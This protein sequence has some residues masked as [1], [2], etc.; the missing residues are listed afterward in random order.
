MKEKFSTNK[1]FVGGLPPKLPN[2]D[3]VD[4]FKK[5]GEVS[6][7]VIL[8]SIFV[9]YSSAIYMYMALYLTFVCI[10]AAVVHFCCHGW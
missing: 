2:E 1:L 9:T 4:F 8:R 10:F 6:D 5:F 7:L 3:V